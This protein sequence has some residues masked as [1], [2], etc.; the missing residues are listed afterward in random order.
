M[1]K[2]LSFLLLTFVFLSGQSY[3]KT[4]DKTITINS[5]DKVKDYVKDSQTVLILSID[6]VLL[7]SDIQMGR[8]SWFY[9]RANK[10]LKE[11]QTKNRAYE[12]AISEWTAVINAH[13]QSLVEPN[14][15]KVI[16][17]IQSQRTK[18]IGLTS[19]GI[20][21]SSKTIECMRDFGID[22]S[23]TSGVTRDFPLMMGDKLLLYRK[24]VLFTSGAHKVMALQKLEELAGV[25]RPK[26]VV[27][28]SHSQRVLNIVKDG[29]KFHAKNLEFIPIR[30]SKMDHE[31]ESFKPEVGDKEYEQFS[32][33]IRDEEFLKEGAKK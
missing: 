3:G 25:S 18:I 30:Y 21:L 33:I 29:F 16:N 27:M 4:E 13:P 6:N 2:V 12:K 32:K 1:K 5:F 26:R 14:I 24:G 28:V 10:H 20:G 23:K 19:R 11:G 31:K 9:Y 7:K 22:L 15:P 17:E 8:K